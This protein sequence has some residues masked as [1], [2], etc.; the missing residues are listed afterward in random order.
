MRR[1]WRR[2]ASGIISPPSEELFINC[3]VAPAPTSVPCGLEYRILGLACRFQL[4]VGSCGDLVLAGESVE[5][6]SAMNLM[7]G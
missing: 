5:D 3:P 6:Q 1:E 4:P 2:E 7:V